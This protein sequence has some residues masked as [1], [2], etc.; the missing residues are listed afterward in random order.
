MLIKTRKLIHVNIDK[1]LVIFSF[2]VIIIWRKSMQALN[3][4]DLF[5][6]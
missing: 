6:V 3:R 2:T 1:R 5:S 4:V